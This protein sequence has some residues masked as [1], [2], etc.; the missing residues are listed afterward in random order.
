MRLRLSSTPIRHVWRNHPQIQGLVLE[1]DLAIGTSRLRAKLLV[2]DKPKS[3]R[4]FWRGPLGRGDLGRRC[5]GAVN[6]L[7]CEVINFHKDGS[8]SSFLEV[9]PRYFC[10]IGLVKTHLY[11]EIICHE[12]VHA[13]FNYVKR[14]KRSPWDEHA[15]DFDEESICYPAG[16]IAAEINNAL[17]RAK[18]I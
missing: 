7:F 12:A 4:L 5:K 2:F 3:L 16:R 14:I 10:V 11:G 13:A 15:R 18:L 1:K 17:Y 9:D 6:G 8:E